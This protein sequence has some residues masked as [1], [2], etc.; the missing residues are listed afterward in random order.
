MR[1]RETAQGRLATEADELSSAGSHADALALIERALEFEPRDPMILA[2]RGRELHALERFDEAERSLRDALG[3]DRGLTHAWNELGMLMRSRGF[4]E[5][6]A[7]CF[8]QSA[9]VSPDV[10]V[11]T[12]LANMQLAFDPQKSVENAESALAIDPDWD[13]AQTILESAKRKLRRRGED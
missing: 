4:F 9:E 2:Y 10:Y 12:I 6:A 11:L 1:W 13:E 7:F 8:E 3:I 5:K